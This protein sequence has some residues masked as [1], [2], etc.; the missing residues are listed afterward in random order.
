MQLPLITTCGRKKELMKERERYL[1]KQRREFIIPVLL[2]K[3]VGKTSLRQLSK[4]LLCVRVA[5]SFK[6]MH[7]FI[8]A[9]LRC[10]ISL[11]QM[12]VVAQ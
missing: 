4:K 11:K 10:P 12:T 9:A 3:V 7:H 1:T 6:L 2:M 8:N 5:Q